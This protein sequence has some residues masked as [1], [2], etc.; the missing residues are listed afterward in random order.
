M[1]RVAGIGWRYRDRLAGVKI[2]L[3][4]WNPLPTCT[5]Q[6]PLTPALPLLCWREH[7]QVYADD[8][9]GSHAC[10]RQLIQ[11]E[12][13][14]DFEQ[15]PYG[16]S[17]SS[18]SLHGT[19]TLRTSRRVQSPPI[20]AGGV[21]LR[22]KTAGVSTAKPDEGSLELTED[23][24]RTRAYQLYEERGYE[25][26]HDLEDWLRAEGEIIGK[27]PAVAEKATEGGI[28]AAVA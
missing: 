16:S 13:W 24:I 28:R 14:Q 12:P 18:H 2:E 4:S 10:L 11:L 15:C 25:D 21:P 20:I 22:H 23:I 6:L 7:N 27:K 5:T 3:E 17:A 8:N 9:E 26:G 1:P 19:P